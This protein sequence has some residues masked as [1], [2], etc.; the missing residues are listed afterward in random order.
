MD[1]SIG[2]VDGRTVRACPDRA[3]V[4]GSGDN[5]AGG[6]RK[7]LPGK[8]IGRGSDAGCRRAQPLD[9]PLRA[10]RS[11]A[12]LDSR[13]AGA[14]QLSWG[15]TGLHGPP[16]GESGIC[17]SPGIAPG[18][19]AVKPGSCGGASRPRAAR[20]VAYGTPSAIHTAFQ[21]VNRGP[22]PS[23]LRPHA[24][25]PS[26]TPRFRADLPTRMRRVAYADAQTSLRERVVTPCGD[27][28]NRHPI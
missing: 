12:E 8:G 22:T 24:E 26:P 10:A 11:A 21:A 7:A 17:G 27:L 1:V 14:V 4:D 25:S 15:T 16:G 19:G 20:R 28:E 9:N 2:A 3:P 13:P 18:S 6:A 23:N 5:G